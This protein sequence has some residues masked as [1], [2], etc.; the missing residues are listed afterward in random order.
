MAPNSR[1]ILRDYI[2]SSAIIV[3]IALAVTIVV[4]SFFE[5]PRLNQIV[6][7]HMASKHFLQRLLAL[8]L[9]FV[10]WNLSLRK[11]AAWLI[12]ILFLTGSLFL[13]LALRHHSVT[14]LIII[15]E[16]YALVALLATQSHFRRPSN[17]L[18]F[19]R[20]GILTGFILTAVL[21]NAA[22][23]YVHLGTRADTSLSFADSLRGT[24]EMLFDASG[25]TH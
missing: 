16:I 19:K 1:R 9:L 24:V 23:G 10:A 11:R 21:L 4:T 12:C 8:G 17:R 6:Y 14:W 7:H 3:V 15:F 22:I 13:N 20:A 5:L 18:S 25:R 2:A